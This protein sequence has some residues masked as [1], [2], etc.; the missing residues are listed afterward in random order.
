M[1]SAVEIFDDRPDKAA[2][3][4][5]GIVTTSIAVLILLILWL[6]KI[7]IPIP[8]IPP[9]QTVPTMELFPVGMIEG[10]T[11]QELGGG[12]QGNTGDPGSQNMDAAD[13]HNTPSNPG[14]I[15][16]PNS[17]AAYSA[18]HPTPG[19]DKASVSDETQAL[20]DKLK[21]KKNNT[22]IKI[23]GDGSGS[24]YTSGSGNGTGPGVGPN[25]GGLPGQ[26]GDGGGKRYRKILF[27]PDIV[28]PT[29][30]EGVVAV[31]IRV[32][33]DGT[34]AFAEALSAGSTTG[35]PI[36]K[37]T[38]AQSAYKIIFDEDPNG[39]ELLELVVNINFTLQK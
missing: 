33:K 37:S 38:A 15:T 7:V 1:T 19:S 13:G 16:N 32:R 39:P 34:V 14:A 27:K 18:A 23:G 17:D 31:K 35:N 5:A 21:N 2:H 25:D 36:L 29:Q 10:G 9:D 28:N 3:T 26:G 8:P 12:S 22:S 20:L 11:N 24:P 30:E 6:W 4:T